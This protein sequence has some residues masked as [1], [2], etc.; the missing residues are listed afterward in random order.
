MQ[1]TDKFFQVKKRLK[2]YS[3][4][5]NDNRNKKNAA[6]KYAY[7]FNVAAVKNISNNNKFPNIILHETLKTAIK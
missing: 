2:K 6:K 4:H 5:N 1:C 7:I 3:I